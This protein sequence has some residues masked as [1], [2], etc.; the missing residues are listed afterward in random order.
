[1]TGTFGGL[2]P[3]VEIDGRRI[4]EGN[5]GPM[6]RRLSGAYQELVARHV[7]SQ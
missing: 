7:S 4:G 5:A 1:V 3:V 2:T 6:Y